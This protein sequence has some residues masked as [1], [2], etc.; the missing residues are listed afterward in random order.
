MKSAEVELVR[1]GGDVIMTSGTI[2]PYY[3]NKNS[4]ILN[5][6]GNA[7]SVNNT[8]LRF[9][10]LDDNGKIKGNIG[11]YPTYNDA[12]AELGDRMV[13]LPGSSTL[14]SM[15]NLLLEANNTEAG[16][17]KY[18]G[19]YSFVSNNGQFYFDYINNIVDPTYYL[20]Q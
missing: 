1:V 4:F 6:Q 11:T 20:N 18:N 9:F 14:V 12:F 2:V 5:D 7:F 19:T 13:R 16:D 10:F 3:E 17:T 15:D 8:D